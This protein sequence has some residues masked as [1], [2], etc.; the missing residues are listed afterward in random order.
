MNLTTRV[1]SHLLAPLLT[2]GNYALFLFPQAL[3]DDFALY[4]CQCTAQHSSNSSLQCDAIPLCSLP[5]ISCLL[6]CVRGYV[7]I[8]LYM[9]NVTFNNN[10]NSNNNNNNNNYY[11]HHHFLLVFV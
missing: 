1:R 6:C 5:A 2:A 8:A 10:N 11:Y 3:H 4:V 9:V 7:S